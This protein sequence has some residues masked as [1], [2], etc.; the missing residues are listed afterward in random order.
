VWTE[1]NGKYR[2]TVRDFWRGEPATL[3]EFA[4]RISGSADLYQDDGRRP[5]HSINFVTCHDGFT[6]NDLVSYND[7]HNDANGE[8]NRDGESHNRSWNSGVEGPTDNPAVLALRARQRRNFLATLLLSQ[9]VPMIGHGDEL[10]R[11]QHGNNNAYCQDNELSWVDWEHVDEHLLAF[12]RKL[13]AFRA[14]HR[15]FR[16]RRFFS[17]LPVQ[18][19]SAGA[20]LPD[21]AWFTPDG[22]EMTQ[23]DWDNHFGRAV[24]LFVN[25]EGI[26]ERGQY[27]QRHVDDSFLLC[28]NAHDDGLRFTVPG[29][30]YGQK[31]EAVI[32]TA[33][34]PGEAQ[35]VM[36]AGA[37]ILV[38]D[39]SL[40]VLDRSV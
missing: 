39:R 37:S 25:G 7:K 21:L 3:A 28:F 6:L 14:R 35:Q 34:Y 19:R 17:G 29:H 10:G 9:G 16:R 1:W 27:G 4:S 40:V 26:R 12:V 22:R 33:E 32:S 8:D 23:Q 18:T 11:T 30:E 13:T 5:F 15:V 2:D 20:P 31:W 36:E 24:M 38:P